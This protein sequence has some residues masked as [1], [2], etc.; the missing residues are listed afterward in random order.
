MNIRARNPRTGAYDY[1]FTPP[2]LAE[3]HELAQ[4]QRQ[5]QPAWAALPLA[6]RGAVLQRWQ[7]AL[8]ANRADILAALSADTGRYLLATI[9]LDGVLR[10]IDRW[11]KLAPAL[12]QE[13]EQQSVAMPSISFR[14]Q[15]VPY[16]LVG[17]ISPWNFPLTLSLIDA[18]PALIAGC[19]LIIKPSEVTPRFAEPLRQSI[20]AV[21]EL[22]AVLAVVPGAGATGAALIEAVDAVCFTGSVNTG[23]SVAEACARRFIPAFLE[24]GGKDPVIVTAAANLEQAAATVLRASVAATGQACQ[25]LERVYVDAAVYDEFVKLLV[26]QA[27]EV[28]LNYPDI[29]QGQIGP[30]IFDRQAEVIADQLADA[31]AQGAQILC[32]GA[33]ETHGGGKW[34]R[35]TV[36][37]NV[38]HRMK[39]MTEETFGPV[40]PVMPYSTLDEAVALAN[41][42]EYGLSAAV[43]AGDL[44]EAETIARRLDAGAIS[45][46]DGALTGLM[47]E[48]EKHSFKLSGLGG[49]R[50]GP[51]SLLR[52]LRKK[53]LLFQHG[54]SLPLAAFDEALAARDSEAKG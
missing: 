39:L 48:A 18:I 38:T 7:T 26:A 31:M 43:I 22:A 42:S 35:P 44:I 24:L 41:D 30:L 28:T 8:A 51:A 32:G 50:M 45:L 10:A 4:R 20:A 5:H 40:L 17:V 54:A 25:S 16:A 49:S 9:E 15:Y 34:L 19:S 53:A 13:E 23:R 12:L 6:A 36:V 29:H 11:C 21:P 1:E 2:T 27:Q 47:Y 37:V 46:N 33:I 52:F 3:L 14:T